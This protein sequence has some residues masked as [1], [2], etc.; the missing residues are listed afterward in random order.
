MKLEQTIL[1][2]NSSH[3]GFSFQ[4]GT[5]VMET[6]KSSGAG[7]IGMKALD[8]MLI[9]LPKKIQTAIMRRAMQQALKPFYQQAKKNVP[10][11][12]QRYEIWNEDGGFMSDVFNQITRRRTGR[13]KK[14]IKRRTKSN[15]WAH[16]FSGNLFVQHKKHKAY[17]AHLTE[18]GTQG[19]YINN[20]FG[21]KGHKKWVKGQQGQLW[22][23]KAWKKK[24]KQSLRNFSRII[25]AE[26]KRQFRLY[27]LQ[28]SMEERRA[29]VSSVL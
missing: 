22:M 2:Q 27:L 5:R 16:E 26:T 25:K 13:L 14:S 6:F 3:G 1:K 7:I 15:R 29:M 9:R 24:W 4:T 17:Y 10:V 8:D 12:W 20:Y 19:H 28:L 11:Q 18:W 21:H 23:T